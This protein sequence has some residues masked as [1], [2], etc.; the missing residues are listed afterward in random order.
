MRNK[1]LTIFLIWLTASAIA[2]S[3]AYMV[4]TSAQIEGTIVPMGNDSFY[5]ARRMIDTATSGKLV[6]F[7]DKIHVPDGSWVVWPWAYDYFA[8]KALGIALDMNP[9]LEPM[10]FLGFIPVVFV[11]ISAAL[12]LAIALQLGLRLELVAIAAIAFALSPNI[13]QLH[14]F[15]IIDHH[16][17]ELMFVLGSLL[18]LMR[19]LQRPEAHRRAAV[20]GLVLGL[21][22]AFH[23][24]S[25]ILQLPVLFTLFVL[26]LRGDAPS[27]R[28]M[29]SLAGALLVTTLTILLPSA[30]FRDFQFGMSTL[31]WFHLYVAFCSAVTV[32]LLGWRPFSARQFG[33]LAA[34]SALLGIPL[35][36]SALLGSAFLSGDII[37]FN[38]IEEARSPFVMLQE[39][40][41]FGGV[42]KLYSWLFFISPLV[43]AY[44]VWRL[45]RDTEGRFVAFNVS[46]VFG[47]ALMMLQY[48]L[49]YFGFAAMLLGPILAISRLEGPRIPRAAV[50]LASLALVAVTVQPQLR[51]QL[52]AFQTPGFAKHY[53]MTYPL[54]ATMNR[55]CEEDPGTL[56]ATNNDGHLARYHTDCSVLANNFLL[57]PQHEEKVRELHSLLDLSPQ[58]FRRKAPRD[59]KYLFVRIDQIYIFAGPHLGIPTV[60][61]LNDFN[62]Q[63]FMDL[64]LA[65]EP[66]PGF[67]LIDELRVDDDRDIPYGQVYRVTLL[68]PEEDDAPLAL[69]QLEP[70]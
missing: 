49:H 23:T 38:V 17:V 11:G 31:S 58:E 55:L 12:F 18:C 10:A 34:T 15:A 52:F 25:F 56:I 33:I 7:D 59:T 32:M 65:D 29:E 6:E 24:G 66:V 40:E 69:G 1:T 21:A 51:G 9:D 57:T 42:S 39:G 45:F 26:W 70:E 46:S 28:S 13:Q 48:R 5:H 61:K 35:I 60:E 8:G 53:A 19:W 50:G 47:L 22:P 62:P 27:P 36:S 44:F 43:L 20:L 16:F 3:F 68:P 14:G 30:A 63:S 64:I 37:L 67:E 2:T 4:R 54:F 41:G